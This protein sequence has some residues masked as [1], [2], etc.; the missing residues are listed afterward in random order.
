VIVHS[1]AVSKNKRGFI[2]PARSRVGKTI[3]M[4]Y[5]LEKNYNVMSDNFNIIK[6]GKILNYPEPLKIFKHKELHEPIKNIL[7]TRQKIKV[8]LSKIISKI[9][10]GYLNIYISVPFFK[11]FKKR[12]ADETSLKSMI[13]LINS[14]RFYKKK[15]K[16]SDMIERLYIMDRFERP[17][18][19]TALLSYLFVFPNSKLSRYRSMLMQNLK[20]IIKNYNCYE[21][22]VPTKYTRSVFNE[23]CKNVEGIK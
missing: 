23:L 1:S 18:F 4:T 15:Y 19:I 14:P 20:N 16:N 5:F 12:I 3:S 21:V 7:T 8:E 6:K 2:F 10:G 9:T 22:G 17:K 13:F 11:R